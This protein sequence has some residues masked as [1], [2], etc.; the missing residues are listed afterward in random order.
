MRA[1]LGLEAPE[2]LLRVFYDGSIGKIPCDVLSR[3]Q[4]PKLALDE[5]NDIALRTCERS[6]RNL[7]RLQ[8]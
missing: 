5:P 1:M 8:R 4:Q 3:R 7:L 6:L 2:L